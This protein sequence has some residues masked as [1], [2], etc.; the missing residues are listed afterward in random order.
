MHGLH[1]L[2][3]LEWFEL[4]QVRDFE[5]ISI[6]KTASDSSQRTMNNSSFF[7]GKF[8]KYSARLLDQHYILKVREK[9]YPELPIIEFVSN[10]IAQELNLPVAPF[11]LIRFQNAVDAFVTKNFISKKSEA[12][13]IH[14]YRY[15]KE[16]EAFNCDTLLKIINNNIQKMNATQQFI[17]MCLFDALIGNHDRHGRNIGIIQTSEGFEMAPVYDNPSFIGIV[18]DSLLTADLAPTGRIETKETHN[19]NMNDYIVEFKRLGYEDMVHKFYDKMKDINFETVSGISLLSETRK[20]AFMKL[21]RK[22]I[23]ELENGI[24]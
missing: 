8:E 15:I 2:C 20:T 5:E 16:N 14:I 9:D 6:R 10:Q 22:R 21:I 24:L 17:E 7:Q 4:N 18:E 19:P 12:N 1:E 13:L 11:Y 23:K 3:F